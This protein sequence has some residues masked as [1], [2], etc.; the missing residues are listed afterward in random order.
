MKIRADFVS[1]SSSSSFMLVGSAFESDELKNAWLKMH[2]EDSSKFDEDSDAYDSDLVCDIAY[3]IANELGLECEC[4]IS[5]Y[6]DM[7]VLGL[8]FSK[9][10]DDETK[11]QFV[12]RIQE[13]FAKAFGKE[14]KVDA[15]VDGGYD[16]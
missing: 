2:P 8:P 16:G 5:D 13:S 10:G 11:K 9:M 3:A 1:N 4:G 12:E 15:I 14:V 7:W 6:Y